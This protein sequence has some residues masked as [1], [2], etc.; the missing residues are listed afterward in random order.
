L[1]QAKTSGAISLQANCNKPG[2]INSYV[3]TMI[4][5]TRFLWTAFHKPNVE[6]DQVHKLTEIS[7]K[8][9]GLVLMDIAGN[10]LTN[11]NIR[12]EYNCN[13]SDYEK[14]NK[15]RSKLRSIQS[16]VYIFNMEFHTFVF[17]QIQ[18]C[19]MS[20]RLTRTWL[21][22]LKKALMWTGKTRP[23]SNLREPN[24]ASTRL[25]VLWLKC[26]WNFCTEVIWR[27]RWDKS[28]Y[29]DGI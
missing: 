10:K 26:W 6:I 1:L 19:T 14:Y 5:D 28:S 2:G 13:V 25:D 16:I 17:F 4:N 12:N 21:V 15:H 20:T 18:V 9:C 24:T 7:D 23:G 27:T 8:S 29:I 3:C 22:I 11:I